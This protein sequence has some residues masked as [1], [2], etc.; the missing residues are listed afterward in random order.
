VYSRQEFC[1][2]MLVVLKYKGDV[3]VYLVFS[4]SVYSLKACILGIVD[5]DSV[6]SC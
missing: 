1:I 5:Y 3:F 2:L 4:Y 6:Y